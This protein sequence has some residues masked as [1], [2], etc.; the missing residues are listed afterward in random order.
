M[1]QPLQRVAWHGDTRQLLEVQ[2]PLDKTLSFGGKP[3][4]LAKVLGST[5]D[6]RLKL[7]KTRVNLICSLVGLLVIGQSLTL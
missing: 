5:L 4:D 6:L 3:L 7:C 1:S 2:C